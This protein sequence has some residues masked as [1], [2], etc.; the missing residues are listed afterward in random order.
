MVLNVINQ[1]QYILSM[2]SENV[3]SILLFACKQLISYLENLLS[4]F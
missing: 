3:E 2:K 1:C 4:W